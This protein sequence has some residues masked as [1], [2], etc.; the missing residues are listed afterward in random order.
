MYSPSI[1]ATDVQPQKNVSLPKCTKPNS[2]ICGSMCYNPKELCCCERNHTKSHWCC[3]SDK[4]E[5]VYNP[6][7]HICCDGCVSVLKPSKDQVYIFSE[8]HSW[9]AKIFWPK[10]RICCDG[11]KYRHTKSGKTICCGI[12][13]YN[14]SD[15]SKKCCTGKLHNVTSQETNKV[16]C[17]GTFLKISEVYIF[18]EKHSWVAKIF[19]PKKRICCDG[20]KY[21][22]TKSGKTICCGIHAYNISDPSKKCCTGKLHNVTSQETNKVQCCGT[23]LKISEE[24]C[25][26]SEK[27]EKIYTAKAGFLCCGHK[28]YNS[29]LWSCC[30]GRLVKSSQNS[31]K[32]SKTE[33]TLQFDSINLENNLC[34]EIFMGTVE[35]VSLKSIVFSHV[36]EIH[37]RNGTVKPLVSRY[38]LETPDHCKFLKLTPGKT[39]YFS[40]N[41]VFTDLNHDSVLQSIY[42]FLSKCSQ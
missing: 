39:Y 32:T 29:S 41:D 4:R 42:F 36:L 12:H 26:T 3:P 20:Y 34:N 28:Y 8:K 14:I 33:S 23:F 25:C 38:I 10:K 18:S 35:S 31:S 13:A 19:W 2:G 15:P 1:N 6:N 40:K 27:K 22:H 30:T 9:V 7:T 5:A 11:Y 24:V 37:G 17:C 21:R 16:Q